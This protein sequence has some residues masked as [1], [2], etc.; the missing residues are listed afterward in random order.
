VAVAAGSVVASHVNDSCF[1]LVG[2]FMN[3]DV[4]T[5]LET[6]TVMET[7]IGVMGFGI[8]AG[9][10]ALASIGGQGAD[11]PAGRAEHREGQYEQEPGGLR[12]ARL[13]CAVDA[14]ERPDGKYQGERPGAGQDH[15]PQHRIELHPVPLRAARQPPR[16]AF[17][18]RDFVPRA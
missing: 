2:R 13:R 17:L 14:D 8:A 1:R 11:E 7:T 15:D 6:W 4:K 12:A 10:F 16:L 9:L 5:T 18:S 3:M